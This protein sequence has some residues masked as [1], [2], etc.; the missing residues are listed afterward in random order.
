MNGQAKIDFVEWVKKEHPLLGIDDIIPK[1][2]I[3][4]LKIDFFDSVGDLKNGTQ[5]RHLLIE[6]YL[7]F[8]KINEATEQAINKAVEIYNLKHKNNE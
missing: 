5:I 6:Y 2:C 4:A 8:D 1:T 7:E 3:N